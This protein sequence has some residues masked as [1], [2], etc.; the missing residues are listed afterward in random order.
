MKI[1]YD[2]VSAEYVYPVS[3]KDVRRIRDHVPSEMLKL[4]SRIRFG[5]NSRTPREGRTVKR[6]KLYDI[7]INFCLKRAGGRLLSQIHE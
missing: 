6:G 4:V 5:C 1:L 7:R 2:S 3:K